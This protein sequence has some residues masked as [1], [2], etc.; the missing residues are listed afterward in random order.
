MKFALSGAATRCG[1][2]GGSST[3][4]C[5]AER[6]CNGKKTEELCCALCKR[7]P[8]RAKERFG[9]IASSLPIPPG[10]LYCKERK[11]FA[12]KGFCKN[13]KGKELSVEG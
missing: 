2:R 11:G 4:W 10:V 7:V 1:V 9:E 8:K 12:G 3:P 13:V 5:F 6:V